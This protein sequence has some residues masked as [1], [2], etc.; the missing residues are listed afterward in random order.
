MLIAE[1]L[2]L[3][4]FDDTE[5]KPVSGVHNLEYSLAGALLIELAMLG[6]V[7]V[8]PES[9]DGKA[10]R[11]AVRDDSPAGHGVLDGALA[12][13]STME[14]RKPKDA[15]GPLTGQG[16]SERL[17]AGLAERGILRREE[18][19]ILK[20]FPVTRWPA[21]D[22]RDEERTRAELDRVLVHGEDPGERTGA[23]IA[24]LTGMGVVTRVVESDDPG[25][26]ERRAKEIAEGNWAGEAM[27]KA[28]EEM[29]AAVM[30]A[31]FV[32]TI[33]TTPNT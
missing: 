22:S 15:I 7:D 27:R 13:L 29:T 2:L 33:L 6:R 16:L 17:L 32:P 4:V 25:L 30:V 20:L 14:G 1:D 24:L 10:G 23:L 12:T 5:G 9:D 21:E 11:L 19:R 3:L 8:T 28:V 31:L 18:G 26:V